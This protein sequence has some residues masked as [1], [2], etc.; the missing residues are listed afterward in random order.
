MMLPMNVCIYL[1]IYVSMYL[2]IYVSMYLCIY[3]NRG[4]SIGL[5]CGKT[6]T[7]A[8]SANDA[9]EISLYQLA[10]NDKLSLLGSLQAEEK[11][12]INHLSYVPLSSNTIS[13]SPFSSPLPL[14]LPFALSLF[15]EHHSFLPFSIP[16][17]CHSSFP[18]YPIQAN[19]LLR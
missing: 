19:S 16:Y 15:L 2:C 18:L 12:L 11:K 7:L 10:K 5:S 4:E 3:V 6:G 8:V 13:F 9:G 17:I 14:P 1:C